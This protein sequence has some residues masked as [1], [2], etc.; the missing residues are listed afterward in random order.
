MS[1]IDEL[2]KSLIASFDVIPAKAGIQYFQTVLNTAAAGMTEFGLF[3]R[4]SM[5]NFE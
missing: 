1:N 2:V 3:T 4:L 5:L